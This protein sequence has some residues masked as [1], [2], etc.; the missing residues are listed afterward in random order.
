MGYILIGYTVG[1]ITCIALFLAYKIGGKVNT[2]KKHEEST[3]DEM[4][5]LKR[6]RGMQNIMD[7][8]IDVAIGRREQI[9]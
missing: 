2:P 5:Q 3:K 7:Y 8:D 4:E 6:Q 9:E 1:L